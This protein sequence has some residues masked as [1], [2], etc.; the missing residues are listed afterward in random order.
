MGWLNELEW[1]DGLIYANIWQTE[2]IAQIDPTTGG[3]VGWVVMDGL[4]A[5]MLKTT[6]D[7][8]QGSAG[9]EVLNGIAWDS[10]GGRLYLTGKLWPKVYQVELRPMYMD[11][12]ATDVVGMTAKIR[13][14]CI[15]QSGKRGRLQ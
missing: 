3:V 15:V 2:C 7:V 8:T 10:K 12:K 14:A 6:P 5:N 11:S 9:P 4:K 1:V 13:K